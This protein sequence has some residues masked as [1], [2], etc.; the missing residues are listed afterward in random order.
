MIFNP[1]DHKIHW[2][3]VAR[4]SET[5]NVKRAPS[6]KSTLRWKNNREGVGVE[7]RQVFKHLEAATPPKLLLIQASVAFGAV[8]RPFSSRRNPWPRS[9]V[10]PAFRT[11]FDT[12][13]RS[14]S[15]TLERIITGEIASKIVRCQAGAFQAL[16]KRR[17]TRRL[18]NCPGQLSLE[19]IRTL[20]AHTRL[21]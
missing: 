12:R 2:L 16:V 20:R 21:W 1:H 14:A 8:C 19:L 3:I 10:C 4:K 5:S 7:A 15:I 9:K 13:C 6:L 17:Y 18:E 11:I